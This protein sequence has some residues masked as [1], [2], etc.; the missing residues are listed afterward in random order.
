[1]FYPKVS[2]P[3][4]VRRTLTAFGGY[5]HELTAA[6]GEWYDEENMTDREWPAAASREPRYAGP[7]VGSA[8]GICKYHDCNQSGCYGHGCVQ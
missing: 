3:A 7:D 1:M 5:R 6:E 4:T 8:D 2:G